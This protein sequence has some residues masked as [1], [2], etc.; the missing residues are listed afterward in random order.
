MGN[1]IPGVYLH[2]VLQLTGEICCEQAGKLGVLNFIFP[3]SL[4]THAKLK[5]KKV[6]KI[7]FCRTL[8]TKSTAAATLSAHGIVFEV[9]VH[10]E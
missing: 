8:A 10:L 6:K 2:C 4:V 9:R 5:K 7:H 1:S 3:C